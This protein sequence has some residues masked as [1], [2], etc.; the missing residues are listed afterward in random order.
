MLT[1]Y[2]SL[3][4]FIF[5]INVKYREEENYYNNIKTPIDILLWFK[6]IIHLYI[7]LTLSTIKSLNFILSSGG[8]SSIAKIK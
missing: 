6:G 4:C 8:I 1:Y 5:S 7:F 3:I 2:Y